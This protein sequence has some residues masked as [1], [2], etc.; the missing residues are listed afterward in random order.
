ML[1]HRKNFIHETTA[2]VIYFCVVEGL[3][4][5]SIVIQVFTATIPSSLKTV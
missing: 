5:V 1:M 2:A 4:Y 3:N